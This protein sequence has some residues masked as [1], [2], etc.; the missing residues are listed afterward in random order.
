MPNWTKQ[1]LV[2]RLSEVIAVDILNENKDQAENVLFRPTDFDH[3]TEI[4]AADLIHALR[5]EA[6]KEAFRR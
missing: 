4:T 1:T 3:L 5:D 2:R 6:T